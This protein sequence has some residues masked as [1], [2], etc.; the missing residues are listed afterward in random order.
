M[1][2]KKNEEE[3]KMGLEIARGTTDDGSGRKVTLI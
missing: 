2:K 3:E 1:N